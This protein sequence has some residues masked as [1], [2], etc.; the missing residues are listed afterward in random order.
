MIHIIIFDYIAVMKN[1]FD[2]NYPIDYKSFSNYVSLRIQKFAVN[3]M[4]VF[5]AGGFAV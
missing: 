5:V 2:C 1:L 3:A 4:I